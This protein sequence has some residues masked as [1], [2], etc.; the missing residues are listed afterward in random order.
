MITSMAAGSSAAKE[1]RSESATA[2]HTNGNL[3]GAVNNNGIM[4]NLISSHM[5]MDGCAVERHARAA[6]KGLKPT[7]KPEEGSVIHDIKTRRR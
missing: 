7:L 1:I 2:V 5:I 4:G 3:K 6:K